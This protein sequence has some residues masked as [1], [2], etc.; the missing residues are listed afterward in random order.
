MKSIIT[1]IALAL[2]TIQNVAAQCS[3]TPNNFVMQ[4]EQKSNTQL[5]VKIMHTSGADS[6]VPTTTM[7]L[8]GL[9][10]AI[11]WPANNNSIHIQSC[12]STMQPFA[13]NIDD[14]MQATQLKTAQDH[15]VTF[16]QNNLMAGAFTTNWQNNTW[17][18]IA[19]IDFTG[20]LNAGE[21]FTFMNCDYGLTHPNS[22]YGNSTTD[23]WLA[24]VDADNNYMQYSPKMETVL[25]QK[26]SIATT[27]CTV[28]PVPTTSNLYIDV[29]MQ[30]TTNTVVKILDV[31]GV[32]VLVNTLQL[33]KGSNHK[34]LNIAALPAGVYTLYITDGKAWKHTQAIVKE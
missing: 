15:I 24:V 3:A 21:Y 17:Y 9:V 18:E 1:T 33:N 4:L 12:E 10:F 2:L 29:T 6:K 7:Q 11:A 23:P 16:Y 27:E 26:N 34:L 22:Y 31:K 32:E 25:P 13:I 14:G 19:V 20:N 5:A 30:N 8:D 28:Y